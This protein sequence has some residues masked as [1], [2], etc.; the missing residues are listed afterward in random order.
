MGTICTLEALGKNIKE[1]QHLTIVVSG[2]LSEKDEAENSW[3]AVLQQDASKQIYNLRWRSRSYQD[4][5]NIIKKQLQS[6]G[7]EVVWNYFLGVNFALSK[8]YF[9]RSVIVEKFRHCSNKPGNK[10]STLV[11]F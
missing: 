8:V 2:F 6:V 9:G 11:D 10:Q 1:C 5:I 3:M 7:M 4:L